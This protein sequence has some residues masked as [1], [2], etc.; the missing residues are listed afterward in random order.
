[1]LIVTQTF[2]GHFVSKMVFYRKTYFIYILGAKTNLKTKF[3]V[4]FR[5]KFHQMLLYICVK[6][7][8][9]FFS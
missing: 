7:N 6:F 3:C 8:A 4:F 2:F 9:N 5:E 1:M